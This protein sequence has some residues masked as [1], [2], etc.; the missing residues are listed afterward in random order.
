[1]YRYSCARAEQ[2]RRL[3]LRRL[4][5]LMPHS[6]CALLRI[7]ARYMPPAPCMVRTH[8]PWRKLSFDLSHARS[9]EERV[10]G[11]I[12]YFHDALY[13]T[14][15]APPGTTQEAKQEGPSLPGPLPR[16][17]VPVVNLSIRY[18]RNEPTGCYL[19]ATAQ[20]C[21]GLPLQNQF[22]L[23]TRFTLKNLA[24]EQYLPSQS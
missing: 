7:C 24:V 12:S 22:Q 3:A 1:M 9:R 8:K 19:S 21:R 18:N 2:I 23:A 11:A 20:S 4:C 6:P 16:L 14:C 10:S 15:V 5:S 17:P 13:E